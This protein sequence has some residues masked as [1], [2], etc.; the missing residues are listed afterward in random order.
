MAHGRYFAHELASE[1]NTNMMCVMKIMATPGARTIAA[2]LCMFGLAVCVI[3]GVRAVTNARQLGMRMPRKCE[4][5]IG[6][7]ALMQTT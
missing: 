6:M 1:A 4:A 5:H 2:D 3:A 7:F